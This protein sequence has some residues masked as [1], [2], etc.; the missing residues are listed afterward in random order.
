MYLTP[1]VKAGIFKDN[2]KQAKSEDT[3]SVE[4]QVALFTFR[5][6]SLN[7][8]LQ[9][10]KKD[11]STRRGLIK[12]VGKRRSLLDYLAKKDVVRYRELIAKL[13]LRR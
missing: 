2:S 4:S 10:H 12:L 8:H 9:L 11:N 5:I 3:G 1:E 13:G 6:D 7:A